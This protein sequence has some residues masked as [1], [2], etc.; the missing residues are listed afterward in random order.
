VERARA[1]LRSLGEHG[2]YRR[3]LLMC[4]CPGTTDQTL[5]HNARFLLDGHYE[6]VNLTV[7]AP[8]PGSPVW[9]RPEEYR[10]DVLETDPGKLQ[11]L[12]YGPDG[13]RD[14]K[15]FIDLW[16]YPY[17]KLSRSVTATHLLV[18]HLADVNK[19]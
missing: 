18:E 9:K 12:F 13:P 1:C 4:G 11:F 5:E 8:L 7:F 3:V 14:H 2:I 10:C 6:M 17:D 15:P 16:D 19:G